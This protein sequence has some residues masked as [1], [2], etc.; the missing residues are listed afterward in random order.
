MTLNDVLLD[1]KEKLATIPDIKSLKIGLE[2]GIGSKDCPFIRIIAGNDVNTGQFRDIDINIVY[3]LDVKNR[4]LESMYE[5]LYALQ[6]SIID[7]IEYNISIGTCTYLST[8]VDED[9]L[10]NLKSSISHF[11]V[12]NIC[13][14]EEEEEI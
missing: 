6:E 9:R 7:A 8:T 5:K 3:G 10:S 12:E 1:V 2:T 4:D 11:K 14:E 13:T